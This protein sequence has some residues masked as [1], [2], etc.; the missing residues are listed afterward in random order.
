[1]AVLMSEGFNS[2]SNGTALTTSN[3]AFTTVFGA[4]TPTA[5]TVASH[6][7]PASM[8]C[9]VAAQSVAGEYAFTLGSL[10]FLRTYIYFPSS[11]P[12]ANFYIFNLLSNTT[13]RANA[14]TNAT[15]NLAMRNG[16]TAVWNSSTVLAP[17][18]WYRLEW[19]IDA[20]NSLQQM[21][22]YAGANLDSSTPTEDS[23]AQTYNQG[24]FDR[25]QVGVPASSTGTVHYDDIVV[26]DLN[27]PGPLV[28]P[29][30]Q[31]R[32]DIVVGG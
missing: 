19:K 27:W 16:T 32:R 7:S 22:V 6:S 9:S 24:T 23:G 2:L 14:R 5:S 25:L 11:M 18:T 21:R 31:Y 4:V 13:V 20:T 29:W 28:V 15:N 17:N 8:R 3:T 12:S 10:I 30:G 1:M 26:D